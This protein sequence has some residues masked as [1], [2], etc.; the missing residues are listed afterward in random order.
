MT[1]NV[2]DSGIL[3]PLS[4]CRIIQLKLFFHSVEETFYVTTF[5]SALSVAR[6]RASQL[7]VRIS[8]VKN[9]NAFYKNKNP[10]TCPVSLNQDLEKNIYGME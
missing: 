2:C 1:E 10:E 4:E 3:S 5:F 8:E 6:Q 7:K 9:T